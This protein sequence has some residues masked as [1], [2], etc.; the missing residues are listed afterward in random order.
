MD[1][2][3]RDRQHYFDRSLWSK[4]GELKLPGL[5]IPEEYGGKGYDPLT[6]VLAF[7][8]LGE[9]CEDGGLCFAISAHLFACCIPILFH[10]SEEQK[11]AYLP[12]LS[13]GTWIAGN[14]MTESNSGSDAYNLSTSATKSGGHYVLNGKKT[15]VSNGPVADVVVTYASTNA[16]KG[17]FGGITSF[18]LE[19]GRDGFEM[20]KAIEKMGTRTCLTGEATFSNL[21]VNESALL[22]KEGG[23]GMIFNQSMEWERICLGAVHLGTM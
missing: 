13:N 22:G 1:V 2:S 7:E 18:F 14:A 21:K 23:G 11:N 9:G 19:R 20:S 16:E 3:E 4:L 6:T 12:K 17:F 10:G 15:F 5:C 8:A